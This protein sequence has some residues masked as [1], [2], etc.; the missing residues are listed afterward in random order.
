[1]RTIT[2]YFIDSSGEQYQGAVCTLRG[3]TV[4]MT[5]DVTFLDNLRQKGIPIEGGEV[6][7]PKDG[8]RFLDALKV[9]FQSPYAFADETD[10]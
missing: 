4:E 2:I 7:Y 1:M 6:L 8:G 5:G 9:R 10:V 3:E